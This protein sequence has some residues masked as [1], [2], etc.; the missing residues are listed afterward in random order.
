VHRREVANILVEDAR[1][2]GAEHIVVTGDLANLG[3]PAE[4]DEALAWLAGLGPPD[5]VSLV[6]GNHDIY[7]GRMHG[8][9]CLDSWGAYMTSCARGSECV[10]A[11]RGGFPYVRYTGPVA[12]IGLNSALPR[13][14]L[15]AAGRIGRE[16][17]ERLSGVLD[18]LGKAGLIRVILIHHPPLPGQAPRQ[19]A[20][21]DAADFE[22]IIRRHGAE[23]VLHGHNHR[24][25]LAWRKWSGGY[26][27][28]AGIASGSASRQHKNE[29]LARYRLFR[30][31]RQNDSA[32]IEM[33]TRGLTEPGGPVI[34]I[35]RR[36]L[37]PQPVELKTTTFT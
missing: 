13:A 21:D 16:Q 32:R 33:V 24:D 37:Y 26:V 20:L 31:E 28:V 15:I 12:L 9:S 8:A 17:L 19:R 14:P 10:P 34:E 18:R 6:P 25:M 5:R 35:D 23:L 4:Y 29:P 30:I 3:L 1:A 7:S 27:P 2:E 22:A 11:G 36:L